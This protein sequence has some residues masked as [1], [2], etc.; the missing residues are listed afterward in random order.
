MKNP[1]IQGLRQN[2][3]ISGKFSIKSVLSLICALALLSYLILF[4]TNHVVSLG[5]SLAV[6]PQNLPIT[7][8]FYAY[9]P[10]RIPVFILVKNHLFWYFIFILC[11]LSA[12]IIWM[13]FRDVISALHKLLDSL[14]FKSLLEFK[15][16]NSYILIGQLLLAYYF[17]YVV[18]WGSL[19]LFGVFSFDSGTGKV[20]GYEMFILTNSPVYEEVLYRTLMIGIPL[21]IFTVLLGKLEKDRIQVSRYILGGGFRLGFLPLLF[22]ILSSII[23]ATAHIY[24]YGS[25]YIFIPILLVG[26]MLG[27]LFLKKGLF[28]AIILH[29]GITYNDMLIFANNSG[30]VPKMMAPVLG[31]SIIARYLV[32]ALGIVAG[33]LFFCYYGKSVLSYLKSI[34]KGF[35]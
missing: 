20:S 32:I 25:V 8:I 28:S 5:L 29:F 9:I 35:H 16:E 17:F 33:P 6:V 21:L 11:C 15:T 10:F 31:L 22:L 24:S 2:K 14:K 4:I 23:F 13:F 7:K 27:Y 30:Y 18:Y 1:K 34:P 3:G 26:L 19:E 12:S